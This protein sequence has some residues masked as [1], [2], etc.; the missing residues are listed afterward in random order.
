LEPAAQ[1]ERSANTLRS[2]DRTNSRK[3]IAIVS[4]PVLR[5]VVRQMGH[6]C[7]QGP[8]EGKGRWSSADV[9]RA[10]PGAWRGKRV[11]VSP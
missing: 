10:T 11:C 7:D 3:D 1:T 8:L 2:G 5:E 4:S 6:P 9:A